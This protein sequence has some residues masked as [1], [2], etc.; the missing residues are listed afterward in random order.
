M[1]MKTPRDACTYM[2][3]GATQVSVRLVPV[4]EFYRSSTRGQ[5][6]SIRKLY[7]SNIN[8]HSS[9]QHLNAS[10]PSEHPPVREEKC[11]NVV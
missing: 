1:V 4:L 11:Q 3:L 5:S 8:Q 9:K 2:R 7:A 10:R 6:V